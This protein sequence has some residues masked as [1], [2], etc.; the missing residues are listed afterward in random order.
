MKLFAPYSFCIGQGQVRCDDGWWR[1]RRQWW[2]WSS[3][4]KTK[5]GQTQ[6]CG[7]VWIYRR[8]SHMSFPFSSSLAVC[9]R[10]RPT[11]DT[12]C[13]TCHYKLE[14]YEHD[15]VFFWVWI[16]VHHLVYPWRRAATWYDH[17]HSLHLE[18]PN[19][20]PYWILTSVV[21]HKI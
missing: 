9:S 3:A 8:V 4:G 20:Q 2:S 14:P 12:V 10:R 21:S 17:S 1:R 5:G 15:K 13:G 11:S 7:W 6:S 18:A 16:H 19:G